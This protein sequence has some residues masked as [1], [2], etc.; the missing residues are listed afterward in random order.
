[1]YSHTAPEPL[2]VDAFRGAA[3]APPSG[4]A[5]AAATIVLLGAICAGVGR[6]GAD[7]AARTTVDGAALADA[8]PYSVGEWVGTDAPA[9]PAAVALL[10]PDV[11]VQ[12]RYRNLRSGETAEVLFVRCGDARDLLGHYPPVCYPAHGLEL[13]SSAPTEFHAGATTIPGTR[14]RFAASAGPSR[15]E[16]VVDDFM[17]LPGGR[18][19]RDMDD[20][21]LVARDPRR[22][23]LGAGQIQVATD[24]SMSDRRR[25]ETFA[26]LVL[27]LVP[28]FVDR[29]AEDFK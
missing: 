29:F 12:R 7:A 15:R 4:R 13:L 10:R 14:Y 26:A 27:P 23:R 9:S 17:V 21:D 16:V 5:P 1:M 2:R 25:D 22:R 18:F 24:G 3:A 8:V 6:A 19:G 20:V 11:L 28:L